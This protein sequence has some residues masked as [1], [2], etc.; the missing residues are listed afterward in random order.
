[1][2]YI[3]VIYTQNNMLV[4]SFMQH[5]INSPNEVW[6]LIRSCWNRNGHC[7]DFSPG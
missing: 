2:L 3:Y 6:V 7:I 4:N 1:M 5:T